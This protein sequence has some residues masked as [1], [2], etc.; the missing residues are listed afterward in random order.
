MT[1]NIE[2]LH[3]GYGDL[4]VLN[5]VN[6]DVQA[7]ELVALIGANGVGKSTLINCISGD[8]KPKSGKIIYKGAPIHHLKPSQIVELGISQVPEGRLVFPRMSVL[9]NLE[10]GAFLVKDGTK[11]KRQLDLVYE[12]FPILKERARQ[13][14][15][16]LSGGEQQMLAIGRALMASPEMILFDEPSLGLAPILVQTVMQTIVRINQERKITIL[17]VEQ[18]VKHSCKISDRAFVME[19]GEI[20]IQGKGCEVLQNKHVQKAYLG[21]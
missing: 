9:E 12:L 14:A 5:G 1:L 18:N 11:L 20:V 7:G 10:L 8:I 13:F 17:L 16:D 4:S 2:N 6:L 3:A 21:M 19:N 15:G